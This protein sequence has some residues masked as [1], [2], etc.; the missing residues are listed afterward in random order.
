MLKLQQNDTLG[1]TDWH[2]QSADCSMVLQHVAERFAGFPCQLIP[3]VHLARGCYMKLQ[4]ALASVSPISITLVVLT[5]FMC[6]VPVPWRLTLCHAVKAG[7][8][9]FQHL[10]Y[11][12]P[13][14][15]GLGTHLTL[16]LDGGAKFGP[17]SE[18]VEWD[19]DKGPDYSVDPARAE[20]FYAG[21]HRLCAGCE[22]LNTAS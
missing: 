21:V 1:P 15:A 9:P 6:C 11:P 4:G 12:M 18:W 19:P 5:L 16:T 13:E 14:E 7:K 2:L 22:V 10:I 20:K 3:P 17:D 8:A